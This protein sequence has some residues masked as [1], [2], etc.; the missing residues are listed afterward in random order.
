M[1]LAIAV[2]GF[3]ALGQTRTDLKSSCELQSGGTL[4]GAVAY[5]NPFCVDYWLQRDIPAAARFIEG[6]PLLYVAVDAEESD[7]RIL[8]LLLNC[9]HF[10]PNLPTADGDTPLHVAVRNGHPD[11]VCRLL[12]HGA[13]SHV[14]NRDFITPLDLARDLS[15]QSLVTLI[16]SAACWPAE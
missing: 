7:A 2:F 15:D 8:A 11:M 6:E 13:L 16:E 5:D 14:P 3:H 4:A 10:D 9:G 1:V 12:A